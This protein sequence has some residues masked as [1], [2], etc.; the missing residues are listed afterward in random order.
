MFISGGATYDFLSSIAP[1]SVSS[2]SLGAANNVCIC[3][4]IHY[5]Y[6][7]SFRPAPSWSCKDPSQSGHSVKRGMSVLSSRTPYTNVFPSTLHAKDRLELNA[8]FSVACKENATENIMEGWCPC[9]FTELLIVSMSSRSFL[10]RTCQ[11][12]RA[13]SKMDCCE[14]LPHEVN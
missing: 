14:F 12:E 7:H 5:W 1:A 3:W 13:R 8:Y 6:F 4:R 9:D 10:T 2:A 11:K